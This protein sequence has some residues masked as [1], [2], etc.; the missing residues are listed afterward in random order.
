MPIKRS[1]GKAL[2]SSLLDL[3]IQTAPDA[4]ITIDD[5]AAILSFSPAAERMF[6]YSEDE[7]LGQNVS[8][9][10]AE[11]HRSSHD[12]YMARYFKT[13]ERRI[14]GIGREVRALRRS[15]ETFVAELAVGELNRDGQHIF[16]GFIRDVSD[17]VE[18]ERRAARLQRM[19]DRVSR[20]QALGEM[21]TALAHEINQP[22]SAISS[23][24]RATA[25]ILAQTP[26]DTETARD[27]LGRIA[28]EAQRAGKILQRM[29]KLVER[30]KS[31][32]RPE[33]LNSL[34]RE[35]VA[36]C[37]IGPDYSGF[38]VQYDL[39]D[40]LPK[41]NVDRVQIQQVIVNLVRNAAE[42][43]ADDLDGDVH[44]A[45][46]LTHPTETLTVRA[47][48]MLGDEVMVTIGD[49]GPGIP[50]EIVN[51]LFD[52]FVTTKE[53]G[54]G[55]GLAVCRTIIESHGGRIWADTNTQGGADFH[56]ALPSAE[57]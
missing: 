18:A 26:P 15:G 43:V 2:D 7:L 49:A 17:R 44:I 11:P 8:I 4:I 42:A 13:G 45:T 34:V 46:D 12:H 35:A 47:G 10:M 29:R 21:S 3:V 37:R 32:F 14:I 39:A 40:D 50:P 16:T 56:F 24:S 25:R 30:G 53:R 52:P 55:I 41:V 36:L 57:S 27:Q 51:K 9:L 33:D 6:G 20:I 38:R 1:G 28:H 31:D 22:L 54:L 23:F 19:L 5:A 48:R